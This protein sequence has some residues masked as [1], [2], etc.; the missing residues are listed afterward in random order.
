MREKLFS[1]NERSFAI[2]C[3][4]NG[5]RLDGRKLSEARAVSVSVGPSWGFA[6]VSFDSTQAV[7]STTV[8][9]VTPSSD[10][11][12]EGILNISIELSPISS[13]ASA[14]DALYRSSTQPSFVETRTAIESFVRES[15]AIDTE[16]LCILAG[17]KVWVV[18]VSIDI[19]NDD[20]NCI[21]V[22]MMAAMA[23]L[24]HARRP[25]VT[26]SG[27][28]VRI[29]TMDE[30][31]PVPL[32][33]HHIPLAA[34]FALF[35][36]GKPYDPDTAVLDPTKLEQTASNGSV[37][38][39]FNG[40]G[41]VCGV[42][43][44]G[45][46]PLVPNTFAQCAMQGAVTARGLVNILKEAMADA[47]ANHP[48]AS[49]RPMLVD[50]E[51]TALLPTELITM[52]DDN[53]DEPPVSSSMWNATPMTDEAPPE[54]TEIDERHRVVRT[55]PVAMDLS[56]KDIFDTSKVPQQNSIKSSAAHFKAALKNREQNRDLDEESSSNSSSSS[57]SEDGLGGAIIGRKRR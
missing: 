55:D 7:A 44:A 54:L 33:I 37:S 49:A 38:F 29:H 53:T 9:A 34:T 2:D 35:G 39:S 25:D 42:F 6:D 15:R 41:E 36:G 3:I 56:V 20:G 8:E 11:P 14:C 5:R 48:M 23:S 40:Q 31:E 47:A 13:E 22:A 28:E 18:R 32:P 1:V 27:Q 21:D 50:T 46:L 30:R 26:V 12:N 16:A 4:A 57:S 19:I 52:N 51:P 45:G 10:R 43:K 24:L 17:V